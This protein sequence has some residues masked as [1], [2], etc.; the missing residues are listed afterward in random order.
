LVD[1]EPQAPWQQQLL[2][3]GSEEAYRR[4]EMARR[5]GMEVRAEERR[6]RIALAAREEA[7]RTLEALEQVEDWRAP[8]AYG[9]KRKKEVLRM[10]DALAQVEARRVQAPSGPR[11]LLYSP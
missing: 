8:D 6:S 7:L 1:W 3:L 5:R 11:S 2:E 9:I 10:L 4:Q